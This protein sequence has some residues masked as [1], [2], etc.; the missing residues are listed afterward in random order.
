MSCSER[1]KLAHGL[2]C[3]GLLLL[4]L[5]LKF[6]DISLKTVD[7]QC[8][9]EWINEMRFEQLLKPTNLSFGFVDIFIELIDFATQLCRECSE[10]KECRRCNWQE[11]A[12]T[13][14]FF[15]L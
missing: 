9:G 14:N 5:G 12:Y 10:A 13:D 8:Q 2:A 1:H 15:A 3:F 7:L 11:E 6:G 4:E